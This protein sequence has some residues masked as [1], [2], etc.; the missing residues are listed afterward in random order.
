MRNPVSQLRRDNNRRE[1]QLE[2][3]TIDALRGMLV[4]FRAGRLCAYD[5]ERVRADLID[6]A[7]QG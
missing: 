3:A 6:K 4:Y 5:L 1:K 7:E 2:A